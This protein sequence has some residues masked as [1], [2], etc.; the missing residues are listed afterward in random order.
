MTCYRTDLFAGKTC[1][2]SREANAGSRMHS[3][4]RAIEEYRKAQPYK[5]NDVTSAMVNSAW[6]NT[7]SRFVIVIGARGGRKVVFESQ[8]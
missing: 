5:A 1:I 3:V 8:A 2:F 6:D 7:E 4:R